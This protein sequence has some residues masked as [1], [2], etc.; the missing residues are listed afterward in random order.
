MQLDTKQINNLCTGVKLATEL[1]TENVNLRKFLTVQGYSYDDN[2]KI[3]RL[4]KMLSSSTLDNIYF[5][6]RCYELSVD[7]YTNNWDVTEDDLASEVYQDDIKGIEALEVKLSN[8]IQ[9]FS[10]LKPEW[11]CDNLL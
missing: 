10:V 1:K 8:Y 3:I 6:L 11:E 7:Y 2:G 5:E 4:K 9:D